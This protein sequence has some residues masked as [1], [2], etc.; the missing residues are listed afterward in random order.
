MRVVLDAR[1]VGRELDGIG[2]YCVSL[3]RALVA[4][5][6]GTEYVV[7]V[8]R[9]VASEAQQWAAPAVV[10]ALPWG[11]MSPVGLAAGGAA[12]DALRA[13]LYHGFSAFMPLVM[14]TPAVITVHDA[15][16]LRRPWLQAS[17]RPLRM[18]A[19]WAYHWGAIGHGA[20]HARGVITVSE[21]AR[22]DIGRCWPAALP[23]IRVVWSGVDGKFSV[24]AAPAAVTSL[25]ERHGLRRAFFIHPTN[26]KPYK[27]T[28]RVVQSFAR[29]ADHLDHDLVIVGR[30]SASTGDVERAVSR[31]GMT[32]RVRL[33]GAVPEDE[34]IAL[35]QTA[36]ALVFPS[37][38]EGFGLPIVEAMQA[39]TPVITSARSS[40]AEV[41]GDACLLVE[42]TA[43]HAITAALTRLVRDEPLRADLGRRGRTRAELFRWDRTAKGVLAVHDELVA[44]GLSVQR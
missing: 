10:R 43:T 23:R 16:W 35:V 11:H 36:T 25:R 21:D 40:M 8:R 42:P 14:R 2:R 39:G 41:A 27:N 22:R 34:L 12:V 29:A 17:G 37:L 4:A 5:R 3:T 7:L 33:L 9:E 31:A 44:E 38:W 15:I 28:L 19:G 13:D 6:P 18:A 1:A 30:R 32:D 26:G 20:R 24:R